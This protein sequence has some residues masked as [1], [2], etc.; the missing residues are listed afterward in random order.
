MSPS[1]SVTSLA[2]ARH[3]VAVGQVEG[4]GDRLAAVARGSARR[5]P[6]DDRPAGRRARPGAPWRRGTSAVAAPMPELAPVTTAGRRSGCSYFATSAHLHAHR[7]RGEPADVDRV[8]ALALSWSTS[9]RRTRRTSSRSAICDSSRARLAPRQKCRPPPKLSDLRQL[10]LVAVDVE[11]VGAGR[12]PGDHGWPSRPAPRP[13]S[14]PARPDRAARRPAAAAARASG[15]TG[16]SAASPRPTARPGTRSSNTAR[17]WS[18]FRVRWKTAWPSSLVVVSL[19]AT[20]IRNRNAMI[21]SSV[22]CV[23]RR[24]RRREQRAGEVL[25]RPASALGEHLG[26]VGEQ[27]AARPRS[28]RR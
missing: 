12:T 11:P 15:W 19:P 23:A 1:R 26:V 13:S 14:P 4:Y 27:L 7:H 17:S 22:S 8:H 9:I 5:A 16:R 28:R 10:V 18:G 3:R 2:K 6:R 20:T 21:S 25:G 24:S